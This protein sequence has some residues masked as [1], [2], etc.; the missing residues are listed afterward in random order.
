[1]AGNENGDH[2]DS[3]SVKKRSRKLEEE[4]DEFLKLVDNLTDEVKTEARSPSKK[5][6]RERINGEEKE[7][8]EE[9]D[10]EETD[11]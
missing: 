8:G 7:D 1:V 11:N 6:K 9:D 4:T 10:D 3:T 2:H 5:P